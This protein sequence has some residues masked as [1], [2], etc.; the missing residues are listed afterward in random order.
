MQNEKKEGSPFYSN[1]Q[2]LHSTTHNAITIIIIYT[3]VDIIRIQKCTES[4]DG[5]SKVS[6]RSCHLYIL[7][8]CTDMDYYRDTAVD[9]NVTIVWFTYNFFSPIYSVNGTTKRLLPP[10]AYRR[11]T[12]N[13][14]TNEN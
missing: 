4:Y 1:E 12:K 14:K 8:L 5:Q 10:Q 2:Y 9:R 6:A 11:I 13:N 7:R 3:I